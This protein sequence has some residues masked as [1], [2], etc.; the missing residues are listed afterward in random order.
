MS[1]LL[2]LAADA[3]YLRSL[4]CLSHRAN[5]DIIAYEQDATFGD[6]AHSVEIESPFLHISVDSAM[7][8]THRKP[9]ENPGKP[10]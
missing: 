1:P 9:A 8:T 5:P 6:G 4:L 2:A 7:P 10:R 3:Q